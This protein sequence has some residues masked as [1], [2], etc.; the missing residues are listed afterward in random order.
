M[1]NLF[2]LLIIP[3]LCLSINVHAQQK[4]T[5]QRILEKSERNQQRLEMDLQGELVDI[6]PYREKIEEGFLK[7]ELVRIDFSEVRSKA[8]RKNTFEVNLKVGELHKWNLSLYL[9]DMR[10]PDYQEIIATE[11]GPI[12]APRRP[13]FTYQG[14]C[15]T[16]GS[17][18]GEVRLNISDHFVNGY[19]TVGEEEYF[20]ENLYQTDARAPADLFVIYRPQDVRSDGEHICT[21]EAAQKSNSYE[22]GEV[23]FDLKQHGMQM[24][25]MEIDFVSAATWDFVQLFSN[26]PTM[27]NDRIIAITN[28]VEGLYSPFMLEYVFT[29]Q[30]APA[31]AGA[32]PFTAS[33][34]AEDLLDDMQA[35]AGPNLPTHDL[36]QIWTGRDIRGCYVGPNPTNFGLIGCAMCIGCVC[37][38]ERYNVCENWNGIT[39][40]LRTL[41]A[42]ECGHNFDGVHSQ[43]VAGTIMT[44][45]INCNATT[46]SM[47]NTTRIQNHVDSRNCLSACSCALVVD[48]SNITDQTL[49]CRAD[50]PPVDYSLPIIVDSCGAV[51]FNALTVIPG[52]SACPG[53]EV[54]IRRSYFIEDAAGN[55]D[56]CR[57]TFTVISNN[58]PTI[59]CP[60]DQF[61]GCASDIS[62]SAADAMV[63]NEC[64]TPSVSLS[65]PVINGTPD[66]IGTTYTYT[67]TVIDHCNRIA[68]CEQVF[69]IN[70]SSIAIVDCPD[71]GD[72]ECAADIVVD[73]TDIT[74]TTGCNVGFNVVI[75]GPTVVGPPDCP[76]TTYSYNYAATSVC[77]L[78]ASCTRVFTIANDAPFLTCPADITV[79]CA[80]D[81]IVDESDVMV[82]AACGQGFDVVISG[83]NVLGGPPQC[84]G[85]R[86]RYYYNVT[87][88]CGR[89][90]ICF[91]EF[92]IDN[93]GPTIV[94]S[95]DQ[96]V[97]CAEDIVIDESEVTVTT[98]CMMNTTITPSGPVVNGDP[99][100]PGTT[101]T[102]TYMVEDDCGRSASCDKVW[103]IMNAAPQILTCAPDRIVECSSDI[104]S[105][106][107]L[108][109]FEVSCDLGFTL[110][111]GPIQALDAL[112]DCPGARYSITYTL[113]DDCGRSTDCTQFFEVDNRAPRVF[114]DED[115]DVACREDIDPRW[116]NCFVETDCNLGIVRYEIIGPVEDS[117]E[118]DCNGKVINYLFSVWDA[119]GRMTCVAQAWT[120]KND[121]P[122]FD[123]LPAD[124][125]VD[126]S[127]VPDGLDVTAS[128]DGCGSLDVEINDVMVPLAGMD[129]RIDRTFMARDECGNSIMGEQSITVLCSGP[130]SREICTYGET[131]WSKGS[132]IDR[133]GMSPKDWLTNF[134]LSDNRLTLGLEG[135]SLIVADMYCVM[136]LLP[137]S[138]EAASFPLEMGDVVLIDGFCTP[139]RALLNEEER[140]NNPLAGQLLTL[141]LNIRKEAAL[142]DVFL[143]D[144][145]I[146]F[147]T[148]VLRVLPFDPIVGDVVRL[149]D[150]KL[151]SRVEVD[152]TALA[153]MLGQINDYFVDCKM[154][155]NCGES[156]AEEATEQ[157]GVARKATPAL[158]AQLQIAPNPALDEVN[159]TFQSPGEQ[160]LIQIF[161]ANGQLMHTVLNDSAAFSQ[162][163]SI[164]ISTWPDGL[165]IVSM[166]SE[167]TRLSTKLIKLSD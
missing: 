46:F 15:N 114:P 71:G 149:S 48:C 113:E 165:Y 96:T 151:S 134:N 126:C 58:D 5:S 141:K 12:V 109:T 75:T 69:T 78:T 97:A 120:I 10:S 37:G 14:Y 142:E 110:T 115:Q 32:D 13:A 121:G 92:I 155:G 45:S 122:T 152:P 30:F 42:H 132:G 27:A 63:T 4:Q 29:G 6:A 50:L 117:T 99:D 26:D 18:G 86:Y 101:Y 59:T 80:E 119:C 70:S 135:R 33:D 16:A 3:L 39:N 98:D 51:S 21:Y 44:G 17:L 118:A 82:D 143:T 54:L 56:T 95:P 88:A 108:V 105:E 24:A 23:E 79:Q 47:G 9:N 127:D 124:V 81:I 62:V 166:T 77:G 163:A 130:S 74:V 106:E 43:S 68:S 129:F 76:G 137:A 25:C 147:S 31:D 8:R 65:G 57:Q 61:V 7:Y 164:D 148:E 144:I 157:I 53:D 19:V 123:N 55:T 72:I 128:F 107:D 28:L 153:E 60:A 91:R 100:C 41:S 112:G 2:Y 104:F 67:Y 162:S 85:S 139:E 116:E 167:N 20:I 89:L 136:D 125:T 1:K 133:E 102:I 93:D 111:P 131:A 40:C 145:C 52:G 90:S 87:D 150:A 138:G 84:P 103:T 35:Y 34:I 11:N 160:A 36:G 159:L 140:L 154:P 38:A 73:P 49:S 66:C 146:S 161:N 158:E 83:P 64:G 156:I 94:C 22:E